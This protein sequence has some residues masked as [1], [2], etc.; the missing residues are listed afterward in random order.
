MLTD[1]Q[2]R[3]RARARMKTRTIRTTILLREDERLTAEERSQ[4]LGLTLSSYF[5]SL[6]IRDDLEARREEGN[7]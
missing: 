6:L 7:G 2:I 1:E 5:R 4:A 3:A